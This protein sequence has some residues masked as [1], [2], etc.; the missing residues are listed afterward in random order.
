MNPIQKERDEGVTLTHWRKIAEE[1]I[2]G[3]KVKKIRGEPGES[4]GQIDSGEGRKL[5]RRQLGAELGLGECWLL[6]LS[7]ASPT[8]PLRGRI[9]PGRIIRPPESSFLPFSVYRSASLQHTLNNP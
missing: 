7:L 6:C 2:P 4:G 1:K 5:R 9:R 3:G 8:Q